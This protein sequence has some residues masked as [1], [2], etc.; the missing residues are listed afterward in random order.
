MPAVTAEVYTVTGR[1]TATTGAE[2]FDTFFGTV[3]TE[4]VFT[5]CED[6]S[7][8]ESFGPAFAE[9]IERSDSNGDI[10]LSPSTMMVRTLRLSLS[11]TQLIQEE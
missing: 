6:E 3:G 9:C 11:L 4:G 2:A 5:A 8:F 7:S 10:F 1:A